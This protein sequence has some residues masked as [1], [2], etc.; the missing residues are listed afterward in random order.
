MSER[1]PKEY[2]PPCEGDRAYVVVERVELGGATFRMQAVFRDGAWRLPGEQGDGLE[3]LSWL[4]ERVF[5]C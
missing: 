4:V 3:C 2:W 5:E 1:D